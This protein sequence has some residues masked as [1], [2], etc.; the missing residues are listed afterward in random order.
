MMG[1]AQ[2]ATI[3]LTSQF[4][5]FFSYDKAKIF[6]CSSAWSCLQALGGQA[7]PPPELLGLGHVVRRRLVLVRHRR[8]ELQGRRQQQAALLR[9][10]V[11]GGR[12]HAL[13]KGITHLGAHLQRHTIGREGNIAMQDDTG[14]KSVKGAKDVVKIDPLN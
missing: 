14:V 12:L 6:C 8:Q 7:Q 9:V 1:H 4:P 2:R 5:I 3:T 10:A 13:G 11:G